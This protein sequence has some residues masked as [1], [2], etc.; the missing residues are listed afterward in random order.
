MMHKRIYKL[1]GTAFLIGQRSA[2]LGRGPNLAR[3][4]ISNGSWVPGPRVAF[5]GRS[6]S[7]SGDLSV[8]PVDL[9]SS[10]GDRQRIWSSLFRSE[11]HFRALNCRIC[12]VR[13]IK[14]LY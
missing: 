8:F 11:I 2:N 10:S 6:W 13:E 5:V 4:R 9:A 1:E 12:C 7:R 3:G 14:C